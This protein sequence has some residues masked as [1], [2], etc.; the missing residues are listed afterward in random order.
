MKP[1]RCPWRLM[2]LIFL[3]PA[4]I[5]AVLLVVF[6]IVPVEVVPVVFAIHVVLW[7]VLAGV[8]L[9]ISLR[10]DRRLRRLKNEGEAFEGDIVDFRP[11]AGVRIMHY[12]TARADCSYVNFQQ[13][14]CLVRSRAYLLDG[15]PRFKGWAHLT[16]NIYVNRE[17][18]RD[19][20][21][22]ITEKSDT[23]VGVNADYDYR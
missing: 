2:G 11:L 10:S 9:G 12:L 15:A 7:T 21:V 3:I 14:K 4:G 20:A 5:M 6:I 16:A 19:Y 22:E 1:L 17:D 8:F 18:P 23:G 13:K